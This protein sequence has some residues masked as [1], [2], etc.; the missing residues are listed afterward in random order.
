MKPG[1]TRGDKRC[2]SENQFYTYRTFRNSWDLG[3]P[4]CSSLEPSQVPSV[5]R[6]PGESSAGAKRDVGLQICI[7]D[8]CRYVASNSICAF[9]SAFLQAVRNNLELFI[10]GRAVKKNGFGHTWILSRCPRMTERRCG[11]L[12]GSSESATH[13]Q[14]A[15]VDTTYTYPDLSDRL[16]VHE[17]TGVLTA[18]PC[19]KPCSPISGNKAKAQTKSW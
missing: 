5:T 13:A 3:N 17:S 9:V 1:P 6:C 7:R 8:V 12:P 4:C 16:H 18:D 10:P 19:P 15:L 11:P 2:R 14:F